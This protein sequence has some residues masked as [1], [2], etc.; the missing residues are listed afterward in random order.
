[1]TS[2][3][4][5][6]IGSVGL[7]GIAF[8]SNL[9]PSTGLLEAGGAGSLAAFFVPSRPPNRD[10]DEAGWLPN[11]PSAARTNTIPLTIRPRFIAIIARRLLDILRALPMGIFSSFETMRPRL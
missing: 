9:G 5:M 3:L 8:S 7:T 6:A 10:W 4:T 1:M 11:A 2:P